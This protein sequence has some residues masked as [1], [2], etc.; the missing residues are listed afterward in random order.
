M[1]AVILAAA[2]LQAQLAPL[3][4]P[5]P[6][7]PLPGLPE[8]D[9]TL[10]PAFDGLSA[11][12]R[13]R[14]AALLSLRER[15]LGK[16]LR[17]NRGTIE[18]DRFGQPAR[19][20]ELLVLDADPAALEQAR[21]NGFA[22]IGS[23]TV[24]GLDLTV[25]RLA[26]PAGMTLA[27]AQAQLETLLPGANVSA[28]T[29]HFTAG[30]AGDGRQQ[31]VPQTSIEAIT[32]PVGVIDGA[33]SARIAATATRG[34]APGAPKP[35]DHGSAVVAL[36]AARGVQTIRVADVYGT[37]PA[38]GNALAIARALGWQVASGSKVVSISLVGPASP[39]L[40]RAIAA[41]QRRGVVVVA[42]VG[43]D[44]PA[45]P[46]AYPASYPGVVAVTGVD[47]RDRALIEAG[48]AL[49]LDY[50]AP[51]ADLTAQ[52][53]AGRSVRLRGTSYAAPLV[54][55]RLASALAQTGAWQVRLD[56]EARDL[57]PRG[58]DKSY[59]RGLLCGTCRPPR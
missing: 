43:N 44:G 16:L 22:V 37:D 33:A 49:H 36:L 30:R 53:A 55:A 40:A 15:R 38:G 23:E 18:P 47:H 58:V 42:P 11:A 46:P 27:K 8:V 32:T 10:A 2:P 54:A 29:L 35:S 9:R 28:D 6:G 17:D 12:V 3:P 14:A 24:A 45:A 52:T 26:V 5:V 51:G 4:L 41:A 13:E 7:V 31:S 19:R 39:V 1:I 21:A 56:R 57:G 50:A 34:F 48:R 25:T 20:G 59:G